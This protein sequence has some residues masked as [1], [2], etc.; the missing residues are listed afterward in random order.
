MSGHQESTVFSHFHAAAPK[1]IKPLLN[2]QTPLKITIASS[3][4]FNYWKGSCGN[5][6][7]GR[8]SWIMTSSAVFGRR[9][10]LTRF[11]QRILRFYLLACRSALYHQ[12][13][14]KDIKRETNTYFSEFRI[15]RANFRL[16]T[17]QQAKTSCSWCD[18]RSRDCHGGYT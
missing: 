16:R 18:R 9:I 1:A 17:T 3:D 11:F 2:R 13:L 7:I 14:F 8:Q 12:R 6:V 4:C 10:C 5:T 15:E